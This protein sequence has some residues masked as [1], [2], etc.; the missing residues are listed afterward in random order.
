MKKLTPFLC[1]LL[2]CS[3]A[4]TS[5]G[6]EEQEEKQTQAA[7]EE[8]IAVETQVVAAQTL[9]QQ[10]SYSGN[11]EAWEQ[12]FI[13]GPTGVRI[14]RILVEEG[15][16]VNKGQLLATMNS[17]QLN[18]AQTQ[19]N[20]AKRQVER[21]DTLYRIGSVSGQQF[22]QAQSEYQNALS[23]YNNLAQNTRLTANFSGVITAKHFTAGEVFSPSADAPAILTMM[24]LEPVKVTI[25]VAESYFSRINEG[26][27]AT[28]RTDVYPDREFTATVYRKS[29]T[30]ERG[31]RSFQ[32]EFRIENSERQ[33]RPGMF[34]RVNLNLGEIEGIYIPAAA[35][36]NQPGTSNQYVFVKEG[37][38]VTRVPVQKGNRY[39]DLI[40][41]ESGL[42]AGQA[43]VTEGMA[44]LN[45]G[46]LVRAVNDSMQVAE[47]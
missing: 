32:T 23:N 5:C 2:Y 24:Q 3:V 45:E 42:E 7:A 8:A 25:S 37:D 13:T 15:D 33:L 19:L 44:K 4:L 39:Q 11:I 43:I 6:G 38:R 35:V 9:P 31:S 12:A 20:L 47:Q 41:V 17:T 34:A 40:R 18:Q 14:D 46:S 22:E 27:K 30:I 1:L 29:P 26:M 28:V 16:R 36:V 21:L 10:V